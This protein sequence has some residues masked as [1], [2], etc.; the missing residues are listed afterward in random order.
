MRTSMMSMA[1]AMIQLY[2]T[3]RLAG[4][5]GSVNWRA[6]SFWS[7]STMSSFR[8]RSTFKACRRSIQKTRWRRASRWSFHPSNQMKKTCTMKASLSS[9]R[10]HQ[11]CTVSSMLGL[12]Y[13]H[14]VSP[15]STKSFWMVPMERAQ[16]LS[17]IVKKSYLLVSQTLWKRRGLRTSALAAKRYTYL[18]LAKSMSTVPVLERASRRCSWCTTQ[19]PWFCH[20]RSTTSSLKSLALN[21]RS[22]VQ[23]FM[24]W[25]QS[26]PARILRIQLKIMRFYDGKRRQA[27]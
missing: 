9:T 26:F 10:S 5:S 17:A 21:L 4:L 7:K 19:W 18:R 14:A 20:Q 16:E 3:N 25:K 1:S 11:T 2:R 15:R 27:K 13:L 22:V 8:T 6:T 23:Q 24:K 12:C